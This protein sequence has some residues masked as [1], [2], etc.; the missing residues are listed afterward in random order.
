VDAFQRE[1]E[2]PVCCCGDDNCDDPK[3]HRAKNLIYYMMNIS[4]HKR[5]ALRIASWS[6]R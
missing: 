1:F 2:K 3:R 5:K 6:G 4:P